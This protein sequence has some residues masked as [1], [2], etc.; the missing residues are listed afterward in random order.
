MF[1][2][3][4]FTKESIVTRGLVFHVDAAD[5]TSYSPSNTVW[6]DLTS[7]GNDGTLT[8]GPTFDS[9]NGGSIVFDGGNDYATMGYQMPAQSSTTTFSWNLWIYLPNGNHGNDVIFGNRYSGYPGTT[10]IKITPT[11][12]EYNNNG[13][14]PIAYNIPTEQ[15]VNLCVVKDQG[16]HYY[17]SNGSQVGTRSANLS[18][19]TIPVFMGADGYS[20]V[21]EAS[22]VKFA[23][24]AIDDRALSSTEVLQNYNALKGRFG[25]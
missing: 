1:T 22:N 15:W 8:N 19:A 9:G 11:Q 24:A 21:R 12:W 18:V 23:S 7:N 25:L 3:L 2:P 17:Y 14:Q 10:F 5:R 16:T 13:N 6:N 4:A 20:G